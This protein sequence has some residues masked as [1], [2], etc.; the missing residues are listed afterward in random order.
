MGYTH[1][2]VLISVTGKRQAID[3]VIDEFGVALYFPRTDADEPPKLLEKFH[4]VHI[5]KWVPANL[6]QRNKGPS[7]CLDLQFQTTKGLK[8]LRMQLPSAAEVIFLAKRIYVF[9]IQIYIDLGEANSLCN[10][11]SLCNP[12]IPCSTFQNLSHTHRGTKGF[13]HYN[14]FMCFLR[15]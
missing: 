11:Y 14:C 4:Y 8:D 2:V 9:Q 3:L 15:I 7:T 10:P 1:P 6:R 13:I 5:N 12:V